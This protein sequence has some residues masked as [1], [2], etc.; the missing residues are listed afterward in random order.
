MRHRFIRLPG[1]VAAVVMT[2]LALA[3]CSAGASASSSSTSRAGGTKATTTSTTAPPRSTT[4]IP[5][6]AA[7][8]VMI[9]GKRVKVPTELKT[10][11]I[12]RERDTGQQVVIY[13]GYFAPETLTANS[14][15]IV[16]TNLTDQVQE[17][18]FPYFPAPAT[19]LHSGPIPPGQTF[20]FH[21]SGTIALKYVGSN[22]SFGYLDIGT[23]PGL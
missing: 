6:P 22:G 16:F 13:K 1:C 18:T 4:T 8:Y 23:V 5:A 19:P 15:T 11:P 17:V 3:A 9:K 10:Y 12:N 21:H 7:S 14:G 2:G 20:K